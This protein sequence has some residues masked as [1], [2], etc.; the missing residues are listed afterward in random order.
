MNKLGITL[1]PKTA[2]ARKYSKNYS[3]MQTFLSKIIPLEK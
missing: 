1:N 3:R 2:T